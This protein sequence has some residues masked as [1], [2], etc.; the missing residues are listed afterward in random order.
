MSPPHV[1]APAIE[2]G[3]A[4]RRAVVEPGELCL[5]LEVAGHPEPA[6]EDPAPPVEHRGGASGAPHGRRREAV[7]RVEAG[8]DKPQRR[9]AQ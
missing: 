7:T 5:A 9:A 4:T 3:C 1:A 2:Q 8:D 6:E